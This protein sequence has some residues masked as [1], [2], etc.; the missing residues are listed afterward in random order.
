M[1]HLGTTWQFEAFCALSACHIAPGATCILLLFL[2]WLWVLVNPKTELVL[3]AYR[4][5]AT[6]TPE[7]CG[8]GQ[9][10]GGRL[11]SH[12]LAG[13]NWL[14]R[15]WAAGRNMLLADE[16]GLGK[17][18]TIVSFIQCLR[19]D[20]SLLLC[21]KIVHCLG[22]RNIALGDLYVSVY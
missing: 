22:P 14:R 21:Y 18:A 12:Q 17:T 7:R 2:W 19:C 20:A 6:W 5:L 13:V 15:S 10:A 3:E 4:C 8:C 9:V 11:Q 1:P 16:M